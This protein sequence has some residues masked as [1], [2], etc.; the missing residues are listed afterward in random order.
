M[1]L[2]F[3]KRLVLFLHWLFALV[4]CAIAVIYCVAP[5]IMWDGFA[6]V[7][8]KIGKRQTDI[9]GAAFLAVYVILMIATVIIIFANREKREERTFIIVDNNEKGRTRIAVSAVEQMIRQAVRGISDISTMKTSIRNLGES[10]SIEADVVITD[11]AHIPTVTANIQRSV[12]SYIELNCGVTVQDISV[13]VRA[14]E[15]VNEKG[16]RGRKDPAPA[17]APVEIKAEE[18]AV[19]VETVESCPEIDIHETDVE[20]VSDS[21]EHAEEETEI[22]D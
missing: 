14:L 17:P 10:I 3:G 15:Q 16:R 4:G 7:Y 18:P 2:N 8:D 13:N 5:D 11:S 20:T 21:E 9:I 22:I 6:I 1:K 12:R 19:P